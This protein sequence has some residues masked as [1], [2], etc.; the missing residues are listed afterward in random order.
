MV[1][2]LAIARRGARDSARIAEQGAREVEARER[3]RQR[4]VAMLVRGE[5][6]LF[7]GIDQ[8][9]VINSSSSPVVEVQIEEVKGYPLV[10][11]EPPSGRWP[12]RPVVSPRD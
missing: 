2:A 8:V 11:V 12:V 1:V 4:A 7:Q 3:R 6:G 5:F 10:P 9:A